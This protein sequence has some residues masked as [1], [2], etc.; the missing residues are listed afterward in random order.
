MPADEKKGRRVSWKWYMVGSGGPQ[1]GGLDE[2]S[3]PGGGKGGARGVQPLVFWMK[4]IKLLITL[5]TVQEPVKIRDI[6]MR[7]VHIICTGRT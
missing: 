1:S 7:N 2:G 3:W 6:N 5:H 4:T